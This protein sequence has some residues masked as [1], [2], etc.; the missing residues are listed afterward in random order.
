MTAGLKA[1][2]QCPTSPE[3]LGL[4]HLCLFPLP[5][6]ASICGPLA[7]AVAVADW[8]G[9]EGPRQLF[10][11]NLNS[12]YASKSSQMSQ[13]RSPNP[14]WAWRLHPQC[15]RGRQEWNSTLRPS[16]GPNE[17]SGFSNSH[18]LNCPPGAALT[19]FYYLPGK[20]QVQ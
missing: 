1:P 2:A 3:V 11:E 17:A 7:V 12:K 8:S 10:G 18:L 14:W 16:P 13:G 20:T 4:G 9:G 5:G 15:S 19:A 6:G